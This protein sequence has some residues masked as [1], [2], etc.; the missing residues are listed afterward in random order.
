MYR[1]LNYSSLRY[2][3]VYRLCLS[4]SPPLIKAFDRDEPKQTARGQDFKH[5]LSF[6]RFF[7]SFS[8]LIIK[9][10]DAENTDACLFLNV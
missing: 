4:A 8:V 10:K 3:S 2:D 1:R 5:V 6:Q 9:E 7:L